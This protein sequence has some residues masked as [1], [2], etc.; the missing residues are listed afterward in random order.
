MTRRGGGPVQARAWRSAVAAGALIVAAGAAGIALALHAR[1]VAL[2]V[3]G[4]L[5]LAGTARVAAR[6]SLLVAATAV[7]LL[8]T[9]TGAFF[10][11]PPWV[12]YLVA[13]LLLV[14]RRTGAPVRA[15]WLDYVLVAFLLYGLA[16]SVIGRVFF[17]QGGNA[18]AF[19][20]PALIALRH[21]TGTV[22]LN[23]GVVRLLVRVFV[24]SGFAY[25]VASV[26]VQVTQPGIDTGPYLHTRTY[27]A[28]VAVAGA[29]LLRRWVLFV[30]GCGL[31]ILHFSYYP[32]LTYALVVA[33][34]VATVLL[35]RSRFGPALVVLGGA[36]ASV[37]MLLFSASITAVRAQYFDAVGK[38][39]NSRARDDLLAIGLEKFRSSPW[40]G[41]GFLQNISVPTPRSITGADL[42]PLH[43][44]FLQFG[45]GGGV[46]ALLA[47]A[48][49]AIAGAVIGIRASRR[50]FAAGREAEGTLTTLLVTAHVGLFL[51][52]AVNPV[53]IEPGTALLAGVLLD[54]LLTAAVLS[55]TR[56][57]RQVAE[58]AVGV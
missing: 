45:V 6:T 21:L 34:A 40:F 13:V 52:A 12:S 22:E 54:L 38:L 58:E 56:S 36:A 46:F 43:D 20:A 17:A 44:D 3:A 53:L 18:L 5:A 2:A 55:G 9:A 27:W 33:A 26:I 37:A 23:P 4:V 15:G 35:C 31:T 57:R 39:D 48:C 49:W 29:Y 50:L 47:A 24:A 7:V 19:F 11:L 51:T 8:C 30:L 28:T 10:L 25:L 16:G 42:T 1:E 14:L 32:A 41:S